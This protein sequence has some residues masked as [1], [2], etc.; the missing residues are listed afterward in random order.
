MP[1]GFKCE[2]GSWRLLWQVVGVLW[3]V[4]VTIR[5]H[6]YLACGDERV[7]S[8]VV[9][10][11]DYQGLWEGISRWGKGGGYITFLWKDE[12]S[13][14]KRTYRNLREVFKWEGGK[15][16]VYYEGHGKDENYQV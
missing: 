1:R 16:K 8:G 13:E 12:E 3:E 11:N 14:G 6:G 10:G 7:T 2:T 4:K 15:A 5:V 9:E